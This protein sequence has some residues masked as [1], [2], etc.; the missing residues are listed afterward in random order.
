MISDRALRLVMA[1]LAA[2]TSGIAAYL[3]YAHYTGGSV[4]CSTGGCETVEQSNYADV[5]GVPV[6]LIGLIG[7]IAI[8]LTLLRGDIL[9]RAA[10]LTLTVSAFFFA[11]YLVLVQLVVIGAVCEWCMVNDALVA[12]LAVVA[13]WRASR[14]LRT[15]LPA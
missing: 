8:L 2:A 6:A 7:S 4:V 14:D 1:A 3:L 9:A 10:G 11:S 5:F 15:P 12:V 13:G